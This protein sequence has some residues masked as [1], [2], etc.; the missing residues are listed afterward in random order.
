ML[1]KHLSH[2]GFIVEDKNDILV[3]DSILPM[4]LSKENKNIYVFASHSHGDHFVLDSVKNL[5]QQENA[6]FIFS[7]D[8]TPKIADANIKNLSLIDAYESIS[9]NNVNI[10][11][12]GTTDLGNSYLVTLNNKNYFHSGDLN[13]WHWKRMTPEERKVEEVDF[14]REV[15][16]F[17]DKSID[18]AFVPVDP[19]LEEYAYL[20]INYFIKIVQPKFVMPMHSFGQYGFYKNLDQH[21]DLQDTILLDIKEANQIIY[22]E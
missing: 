7:K 2:S 18:F 3:F 14:K 17:K 20:A 22:K 15:D 10:S 13:W 9:I 19:R 8:S 6:Y 11:S 4:D 5:Y 16:L 21:I 1:I 12:Y